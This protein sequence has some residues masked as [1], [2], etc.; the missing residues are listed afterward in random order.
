MQPRSDRPNAPDTGF[1]QRYNSDPE[2]KRQ[3]DE[4]RKRSAAERTH[5]QL[6][7]SLDMPR[8]GKKLY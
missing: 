5:R 3:V 1:H 2:F 4:G 8:A 7:E 6:K